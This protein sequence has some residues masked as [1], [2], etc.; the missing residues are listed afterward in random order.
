MTKEVCNRMDMLELIAKG[1]DAYRTMLLK[2]RPLEKRYDQVLSS[3]SREEQNIICD[4]VSQ[5]EE[6]NC[7]MMELA[8]TYM[9]FP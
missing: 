8:C 5:C 7:R 2:L 1:D 9:R 4:F 6:M 3:L